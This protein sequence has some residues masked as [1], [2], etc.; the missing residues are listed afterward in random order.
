M[1]AAQ[2]PAAWMPDK[3]SILAFVLHCEHR[4]QG[5]VEDALSQGLVQQGMLTS[6]GE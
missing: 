3:A 4:V 2:Q 6:F 1:G 5:A